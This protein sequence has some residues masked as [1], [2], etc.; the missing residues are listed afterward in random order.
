MTMP[1]IRLLGEKTLTNLTMAQ[2]TMA[3]LDFPKKV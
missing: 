2:M 3:T 1:P